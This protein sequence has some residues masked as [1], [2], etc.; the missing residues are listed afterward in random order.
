MNIT[1]KCDLCGHDFLISTLSS[2]VVEI[3]SKELKVN[4][5]YCPHCSKIYVYS[6]EDKKYAELQEAFEN[7]KFKIKKL[8]ALG[9]FEKSARAIISCK[10][11]FYRLRR[12][13][14]KLL[15]KYNGS[16]VFADDTKTKIIYHDIAFK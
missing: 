9:K 3:N 11:K 2:A 5:F 7:K 1:L 8:N 16:F 13:E 12:Y 4:Y 15:M 6:I 10:Q 14:T